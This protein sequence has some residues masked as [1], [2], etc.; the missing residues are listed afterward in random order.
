MSRKRLTLKISSSEMKELE[1]IINNEDSSKRL[2]LRC[3]IILLTENGIPL[4]EIAENLGISKTTANTWR[5]IY[6]AKGIEGLKI[7]K[8]IGRPSK[9]AMEIL[10]HNF[11]GLADN[12]SL[13]LKKALNVKS[14]SSHLLSEINTICAVI[15]C[16]MEWR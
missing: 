14:K 13:L 7:K 10:S 3:K 15:T 1:G 6:L 16:S 9:I 8:R 4:S 2:V 12:V 11:P 5:Q